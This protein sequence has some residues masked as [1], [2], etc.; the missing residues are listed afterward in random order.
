[1]L[2]TSSCGRS[3]QEVCGLDWKQA[4]SEKDGKTTTSSRQ[5][6]GQEV[7]WGDLVHRIVMIVIW[8]PPPQS[9]GERCGD[10]CVWGCMILLLLLPDFPLLFGVCICTYRRSIFFFIDPEAY[11]LPTHHPLSTL[12]LFLSSFHPHS[13]QSSIC[14]RAPQK[15]TQ[16]THLSFIL[17]LSFPLEHLLTI[18]LTFIISCYIPTLFVFPSSIPHPPSPSSS[19]P[20]TQ[21][22]LFSLSK[23]GIVLVFYSN[24]HILLVRFYLPTTFKL[25]CLLPPPIRS[26]IQK[27]NLSLPSHSPTSLPPHIIRTQ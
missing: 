6:V 9:A 10:E 22:L 2:R 18:F 15:E 3:L 11:L 14:N 23:Y 24:P 21:P 25:I 1:M 19:N 20:S 16:S 13:L 27:Q 7:R 4:E 12:S 17:P 26:H 5:I 8:R